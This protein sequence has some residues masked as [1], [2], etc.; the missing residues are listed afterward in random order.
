MYVCISI[1]YL[2]PFTPVGRHSGIPYLAIMNMLQINCFMF[3]SKIQLKN[4][5]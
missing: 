1:I 2:Y 4:D 3:Y 5:Q